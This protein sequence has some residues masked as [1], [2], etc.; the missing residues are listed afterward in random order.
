MNIDDVKKLPLVYWGDWRNLK[1]VKLKQLGNERVV[2]KS[3]LDDFVKTVFSKASDRLGVPYPE[4][5]MYLKKLNKNFFDYEEK[6]FQRFNS[7]SVT[8]KKFSKLKRKLR[9]PY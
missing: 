9:V 5:Y 6:V 1:T 3:D 4:M 2:L 8:D 7:V